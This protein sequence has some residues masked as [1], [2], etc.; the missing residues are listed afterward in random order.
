M[1]LCFL[2]CYIPQFMV[3]MQSPKNKEYMLDRNMK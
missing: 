2:L 1:I 3:Y